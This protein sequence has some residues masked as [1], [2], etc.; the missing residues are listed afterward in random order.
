MLQNNLY[1]NFLFDYE[2]E[3]K[4]LIFITSYA[5]F[6]TANTHMQNFTYYQKKSE[7]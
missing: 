6:T 3:R 7:I 4:F 5:T 2:I 1:I